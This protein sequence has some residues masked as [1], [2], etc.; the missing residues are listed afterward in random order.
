MLWQTPYGQSPSR[1]GS[2]A[3]WRLQPI[4]ASEALQ[5]G[6][7]EEIV[8]GPAS[9]GEAFARKVLAEKRP[10]RR[11]RDDNSKLAAAK[12]DR[13]IFTNAAAAANKRNR[14]LLFDGE[15]LPFCGKTF[16]VRRRIERLIDERTGKM[17]GLTSDCVTLD[18][19]VCSGEQS[20]ARWFCP[21]AIYPYWREGWLRR[22]APPPDL[23][24]FADGRAPGEGPPGLSG[25]GA[26][27]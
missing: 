19:A 8:E 21:R 20:F 1:P 14:G 17:V 18:G 11:L 12:A 4:G 22:V 25:S 2:C 3:R 6:L 9:G 10:L 7:I 27:P 13:S 24:A 15:M 5:H 26:V 16:R 23:G